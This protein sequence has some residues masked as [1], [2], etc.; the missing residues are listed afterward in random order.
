MCLLSLWPLGPNSSFSI[1]HANWR[2]AQCALVF[3]DH[4]TFPQNKSALHYSEVEER[5][6]NLQSNTQARSRFLHAFAP[7]LG[8]VRGAWVALS[9]PHNPAVRWHGATPP[10]KG[11]KRRRGVVGSNT[12]RACVL[13]LL[14]KRFECARSL[15][16]FENVKCGTQHS[17]RKFLVRP[18]FLRQTLAKPSLKGNECASSARK[19]AKNI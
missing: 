4:C 12:W 6:C 1:V 7:P 19:C 15:F 11:Q 16:D 17:D 5:T 9:V 10:G 18:S 13:C 2:R 14:H 8:G 3:V